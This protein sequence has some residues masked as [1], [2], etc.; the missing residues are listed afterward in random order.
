MGPSVSSRFRRDSVESLDGERE[1]RA[2][3]GDARFDVEEGGLRKWA[4][5][6]IR[7]ARVIGI[8]VSHFSASKLHV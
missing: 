5:S 1:W 6:G 4:D 3:W 7:H 8:E 2:E